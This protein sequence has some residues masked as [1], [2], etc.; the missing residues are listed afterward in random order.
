MRERAWKTRQ[1]KNMKQQTF[2]SLMHP[3]QD[4]LY[5]MALRLLVSKEAAQDA[6]Q[7]VMMKLWDRKERLSTY[8]NIEAFAMTVTKNYCLDQLKL[9]QNNNL[10]IVHSNYEDS[11]TSPQ[12]QLEVQDDLEKVQEIINSLPEKQRM[13]VQLREVEEYDFK[14]IAEMVQ[15]EENAIRVTLSRTRKKIREEMIKKHR[16]GTQNN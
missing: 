8:D 14:E 9:K 1:Q 15:M 10:R 11:G 3:V 13:I 4:K 5:R 16:Y 7:E 12:R 2:I 6:V